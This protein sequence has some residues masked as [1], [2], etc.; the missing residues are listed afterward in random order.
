M[1]TPNDYMDDNLPDDMAC[2]DRPEFSC[3]EVF[4]HETGV[5][6]TFKRSMFSIFD[7][8]REMVEKMFTMEPS[9]EETDEVTETSHYYNF[10]PGAEEVL[11][12]AIE[13]I[14]TAK[15]PSVKD[16]IEGK[17]SVEYYVELP[18][19]GDIDMLEMSIKFNGDYFLELEE[20]E[21]S[22]FIWDYVATFYNMDDN[23]TFNHPYLYSVANE[24]F[25][26]AEF[27]K[28]E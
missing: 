19:S 23:G 2:I 10:K 9:D 18:D 24:L 4:V 8:E 1:T 11:G 3:H 22:E 12:E 13:K 5:T 21:F 7:Y 6:L 20:E 27:E 15:V 14:V 25:E 26:E 28:A 16:E 17:D